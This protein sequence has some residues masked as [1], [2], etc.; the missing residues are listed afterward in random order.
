MLLLGDFFFLLWFE[1]RLLHVSDF[2][3]SLHN[4][5][6]INLIRAKYLSVKPTLGLLFDLLG[7]SVF[8]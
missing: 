7:L 5:S 8:D 3:L 6:F 1:K 4:K 2:L